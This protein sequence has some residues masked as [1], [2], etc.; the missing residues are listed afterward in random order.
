VGALQEG[1]EAEGA[2][3]GPGFKGLDMAT[4]TTST[5]TMAV[6]M[7]E[8]YQRNLLENMEAGL[9]HDQF[10]KEFDIPNRRGKTTKWRKWTPLGTITTPLTEGSPGVE[11]TFG[12]TEI[13]VTLDQYGAW[14]KGS[15]ILILTAIDD[16]L[17]DVSDAQGAQ[18]GRSLETITRDVLNTGTNV[19]YAGGVANRLAVAASN[20]L[21]S[22]ELVVGRKILL[23]FLAR[24]VD[25]GMFGAIISPSTEADILRDPAIVAA[26]NAGAKGGQMLFKGQIA[27]YM[28]I[29]F[30]RSNYAKVFTGGGAGG[31][32]VHSTLIF[33]RD[34]YGVVKLQGQRDIDYIFIDIDEGGHDNPLRQYWTS[35]WKTT[36]AVKIL[37]DNFMLRIEHAVSN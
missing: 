25:G 30:T 23:S 20:K 26:M 16:I 28:G 2:E 17:N 5:G 27:Q 21:S 14:L 13:S 37:Q 12:Y 35:G 18:A 24:P 9:V 22:D 6:E 31:I 11:D 8:F 33:G 10:G 3:S 36:H 19:R 34:A 29:G 32:N 4:I 15:D 7:K 1:S